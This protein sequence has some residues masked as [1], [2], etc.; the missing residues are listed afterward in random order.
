MAEEKLCSQCKKNPASRE[1]SN[2]HVPLCDECAKRVKLR[3][4]DMANVQAGFG[5]GAGATL[6]NLRA[7][8][9]IKHLCKKCYRDLD[10]DTM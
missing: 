2:C 1:C 6:S 3:D 10:I 7:G 8:F 5:L 9:T 4:T